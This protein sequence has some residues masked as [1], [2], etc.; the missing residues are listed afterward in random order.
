MYYGE[1]KNN[2]LDGVEVVFDITGK[3]ILSSLYW[4]NGKKQGVKV[5]LTQNGFDNVYEF[6]DDNGLWIKKIFNYF[7]D[8]GDKDIG[9]SFSIVRVVNKHKETA[10]LYPY[11]YVKHG[12]EIRYNHEGKIITRIVWVYGQTTN[13]KVYDYD[14]NNNRILLYK[15][16]T[17]PYE[18]PFPDLISDD[19]DYSVKFNFH[20][21][22]ISTISNLDYI[23]LGKLAKDGIEKVYLNGEYYGQ[24]L[25]VNGHPRSYAIKLKKEDGNYIFLFNDARFSV[26]YCIMPFFNMNYYN[27]YRRSKVVT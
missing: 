5:F 25:W 12:D 4:H 20:R 24:V 8:G 2:L 22:D 6:F 23:L 15:G 16:R 10:R 19:F 26:N 21:S 3:K 27:F 17:I 1:Y 14:L 11:I 18:K 13:A 9:A 7:R